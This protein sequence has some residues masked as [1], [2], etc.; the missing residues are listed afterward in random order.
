M[1]TIK[2]MLNIQVTVGLLII[3]S[4]IKDIIHSIINT[5]IGRD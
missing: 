3:F 4:I 5:F 2:E 1:E